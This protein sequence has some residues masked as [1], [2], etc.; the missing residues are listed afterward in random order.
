[1]NNS[2]D[3]IRR[4]GCYLCVLGRKGIDGSVY[5]REPVDCGI[6]TMKGVFRCVDFPSTD[7]SCT[8]FELAHWWL[9]WEVAVHF[10][11]YNKTSWQI[12]FF[13][14]HANTVLTWCLHHYSEKAN[15]KNN[16]DRDQ[17]L[18]C[19]CRLHSNNLWNLTFTID[20]SG[21][22][23]NIYNILVC[24]LLSLQGIIM[25]WTLQ[26]SHVHISRRLLDCLFVY[27]FL[28]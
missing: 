18:P 9:I 25:L 12:L 4:E 21:I 15:I 1:M 3:G 20:D 26:Q 28:L 23:E 14:A 19:S 8:V 7:V 22:S 13:D 10:T 6:I 27:F 16:D 24:H 5:N 17:V 11:V 2:I